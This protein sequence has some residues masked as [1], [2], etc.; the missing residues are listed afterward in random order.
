MTLE[1][2]R[3]SIRP[4]DA[5]VFAVRPHPG[6]GQVA[7]NVRRLLDGSEILPSHAGCQNVQDPYSVRCVPQVHGAVRDAVEQ[8]KRVFEIELNAVTD[9][10]LVFP[11]APR[12]GVDAGQVEDRVIYQWTITEAN[13]RALKA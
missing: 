8:A 6:H 4:F 10:P 1:A 12:G 11:D 13:K 3:G 2:M 9:N 5:R 7:E